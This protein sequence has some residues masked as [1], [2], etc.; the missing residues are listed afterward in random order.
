MLRSLPELRRFFP[1]PAS[2]LSHPLPEG[3][4]FWFYANGVNLLDA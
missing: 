3:E 1:H 2:F 4:G